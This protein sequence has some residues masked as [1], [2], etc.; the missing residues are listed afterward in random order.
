MDITEKS[1][2]FCSFLPEFMNTFFSL[3]RKRFSFFLTLILILIAPKPRFLCCYVLV[4]LQ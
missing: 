3:L 2:Y 4:C 1:H